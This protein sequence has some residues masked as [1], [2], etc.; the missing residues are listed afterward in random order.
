MHPRSATPAP[1]ALTPMYQEL[2]V[3]QTAQGVV[4]EL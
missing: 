1:R 3:A 4:P 2:P